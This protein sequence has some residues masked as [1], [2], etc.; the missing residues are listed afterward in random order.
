MNVTIVVSNKVRLRNE[1][2]SKNSKVNVVDFFEGYL[3]RKTKNCFRKILFE[4]LCR[5]S[6]E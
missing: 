4:I 6:H 2:I 3:D 5:L 1:L